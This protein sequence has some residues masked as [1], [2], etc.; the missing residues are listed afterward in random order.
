MGWIDRD[1][2]SLCPNCQADGWKL[3]DGASVPSRRLSDAP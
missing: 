3:L 1:G 2:V